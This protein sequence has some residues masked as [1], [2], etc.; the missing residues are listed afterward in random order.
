VITNYYPWGFGGKP[1]GDFTGKGEFIPA[2]RTTQYRA[3]GFGGKKY[4][5]FLGKGVVSRLGVRVTQYQV[6]GFGGK[7]GGPYTGKV[8]VEPVATGTGNFGVVGSTP[9]KLII[10]DPGGPYYEY[11][12][13]RINGTGL[14]SLQAGARIATGAGSLGVSGTGD[15][16]VLSTGEQIATGSGNLGLSGTGQAYGP[17]IGAS[18]ISYLRVSGSGTAVKQDVSVGGS[19]LVD[20][21]NAVLDSEIEPGISLRMAMRA[22]LAV[23]GGP[24]E[25]LASGSEERF[26]SPHGV[27]RV[28][29]RVDSQGNRL[30]DLSLQ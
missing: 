5:S 15:S 14:A 17:T 8:P 10:G 2:V 9:G 7:L 24:A 3:L 25:M 20:I 26:K 13:F 18:G 23:M 1:H 22:A 29:S 11:G 12:E 19:T 27:T 4:G 30:V 16:V 28:R 21:A 6:I